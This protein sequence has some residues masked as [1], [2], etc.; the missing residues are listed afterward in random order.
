MN[1]LLITMKEIRALRNRV[2]YEER[3]FTAEKIKK[4]ILKFTY[5]SDIRM[6]CCMWS[7][8]Y[9]LQIIK[10]FNLKC[11]KVRNTEVKECYFYLPQFNQIL[12]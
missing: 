5:D 11:R 4:I 9:D 10:A 7:T 1:A 8:S 12:L 2:V 6:K 3:D